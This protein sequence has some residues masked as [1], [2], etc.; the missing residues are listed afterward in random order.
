M[1]TELGEWVQRAA[2]RWRDRG[3]HRPEPPPPLPPEILARRVWVLVELG[4]RLSGPEVISVEVMA[5]R[6]PAD[7]EEPRLQCWQA[8]I[9]G[10]EAARW[11]PGPPWEED[12]H[13]R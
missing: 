11:R 6:P 3:R 12:H 8:F 2:G 5:M 13:G 9:N 1:M 10:G 4:D 7:F